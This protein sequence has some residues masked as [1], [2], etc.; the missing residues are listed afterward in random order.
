MKEP[1]LLKRDIQKLVI[2]SL[3]EDGEAWVL[4][5]KLSLNQPEEY[6]SPCYDNHIRY[7]YCPSLNDIYVYL[8]EKMIYYFRPSFISFIKIHMLIRRILKK[9]DEKHYENIRTL[10]GL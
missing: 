4:K 7:G 8:G 10:I 5:G 1:K 3:E 9:K 6:I 2:K